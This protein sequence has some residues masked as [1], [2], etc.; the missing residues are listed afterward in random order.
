[1][2]HQNWPKQPRAEST[3]AETTQAE[4]THG[5]NDSRPKRPV[6]FTLSNL[7]VLIKFAWI[8]NHITDFSVRNTYLETKL[9]QNPTLQKIPVRLGPC[10]TV[11]VVVLSFYVLVFIYII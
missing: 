9:W 7:R 5:R 11:S 3:Q 2:T 10:K 1:M 8:C 6:T 4:T